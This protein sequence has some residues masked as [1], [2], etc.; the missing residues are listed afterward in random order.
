MSPLSFGE[1]YRFLADCVLGLFKKQW[2]A[3]YFEMDNRYSHKKNTDKE[4]LVLTV[5]TLTIDKIWLRCTKEKARLEEISTPPVFQLY[6]IY[7]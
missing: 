5:N 2:S 7:F 3:L 1:N 6:S 4:D